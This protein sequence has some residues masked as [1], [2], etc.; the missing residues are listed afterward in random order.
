MFPEAK[1]SCR[2]SR[3]LVA[4][5]YTNSTVLADGDYNVKVAVPE[6]YVT[7]GS[8]LFVWDFTQTASIGT[9]E[10]VVTNASIEALSVNYNKL[11]PRGTLFYMR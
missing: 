11:P 8:S 1:A 3:G 7:P 6:T 2:S 10:T 9:V 5:G 4:A